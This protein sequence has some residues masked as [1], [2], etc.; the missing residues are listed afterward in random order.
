MILQDGKTIR[1]CQRRC[2]RRSLQDLQDGD[3]FIA[4]KKDPGAEDCSSHRS[5]VLEPRV[6][7]GLI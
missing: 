4:K 1:P 2:L 3:A 5:C 7:S 6:L